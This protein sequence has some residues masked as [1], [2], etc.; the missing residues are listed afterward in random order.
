MRTIGTVLSLLLAMGPVAI[1]GDG[2]TKQ[3]PAKDASAKTTPAKK[4]AR[5][6]KPKQGL[7][8]NQIRRLLIRES[9][10]AYP[11][12]CPCPYNSASNG[13]S[14]GGRSAWSRAGGEEPLCYPNDVSA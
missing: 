4:P 7:S 12:N 1:A 3:A 11:G 5:G 8:D 6:S 9:I 2:G 14:C 13:S 10:D